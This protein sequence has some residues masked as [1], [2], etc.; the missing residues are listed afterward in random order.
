MERKLVYIKV[1]LDV[2]RMRELYL[3]DLNMNTIRN[4]IIKS[5]VIKSKDFIEIKNEKTFFVFS[6]QVQKG[7]FFIY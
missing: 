2:D 4:A 7:S 3:Y 1:K 5:K 6:E